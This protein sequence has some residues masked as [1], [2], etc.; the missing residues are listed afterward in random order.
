[1]WVSICV[2]LLPKNEI[3][4]SKGMCFKNVYKY[5]QIVFK[6]ATLFHTPTRQCVR[7]PVFLYP[8]QHCLLS[9]FFAFLIR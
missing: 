7:V 5:C 3:A 8:G 6:V 9:N 2:D 1:M 4:R